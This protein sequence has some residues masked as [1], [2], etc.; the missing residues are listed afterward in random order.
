MPLP[1]GLSPGPAI[2]HVNE[3]GTAVGVGH[4]DRLYVGTLRAIELDA[5]EVV[6]VEGGGVWEA[7]YHY[8]GWVQGAGT[9]DH[10]PRIAPSGEVVN[11]AKPSTTTYVGA[12]G[13]VVTVPTR[14]QVYDWEAI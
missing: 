7:F 5:L 1:D 10:D 14:K 3:D 8:G 13:Q 12:D 11:T 4:D 6:Y 9:F 2:V